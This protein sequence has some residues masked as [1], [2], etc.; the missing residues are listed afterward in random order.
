M[1]EAKI[2]GMKRLN[3]TFPNNAKI[4]RENKVV[5][6]FAKDDRAE[7][8]I[9]AYEKKAESTNLFIIPIP[10]PKNPT[11]KP[12]VS[13]YNV[14][15]VISIFF[16]LFLIPKPGFKKIKITMRIIISPINLF[17]NCSGRDKTVNVPIIA[18]VTE[19]IIKIK[20]FL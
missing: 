9:I 18:P 1:N 3:I 5:M 17:I 11:K 8:L 20:P 15:R 7:L 19:N 14:S 16:F 4:T 10:A 12:L 13:A 2:I 6:E